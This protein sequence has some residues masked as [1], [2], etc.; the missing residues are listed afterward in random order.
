MKRFIF[1]IYMMSLL[2]SLNIQAQFEGG[3]GTEEDPYLISTAIQL[4]SIRYI[5]GGKYYKLINDINLDDLGVGVNGNWITITT[6][7]HFINGNN[8][9]IKNLKQYNFGGNYGKLGLFGTIIDGYI[10]NLKIKHFEI[11]DTL[12]SATPSYIAFVLSEGGN[13]LKNIQIDSSTIKLRTTV[14][15]TWRVGGLIGESSCDTIYRCSITNSY[16]EATSNNSSA[17]YATYL[18]A[19]AGRIAGTVNYIGQSFSY[20]TIITGR[21]ATNSS[22]FVGAV[23]GTIVSSQLNSVIEDCYFHGGVNVNTTLG[24]SVV[25]F[26]QGIQTSNITIRRC[27]SVCQN[28]NSAIGLK[29]GWTGQSQNIFNSYF[30]KDVLNTSKSS[31]VYTDIDSAIAVSTENMKV[32]STF[33]TW[34]F[35]S[36]WGMSP[37]INDGYPYLKWGNPYYISF[38]SPENGTIYNA[39]NS[40]DTLRLSWATS[41]LDFTKITIISKYFTFSTTVSLDTVYKFFLDNRS[42]DFKVV[43]EIPLVGVLTDTLYLHRLG[44]RYITIDTV[45]VST[46]SYNTVQGNKYNI[47]RIANKTGI[48]KGDNLIFHVSSTGIDTINFYIEQEDYSWYYL[49][50]KAVDTTYFPNVTTFT[51]N[52]KNHSPR[53][54]CHK[55]GVKERGGNGDG[56]EPSKEG[57]VPNPFMPPLD[58][59]EDEEFTTSRAFLSISGPFSAHPYKNMSCNAWVGTAWNLSYIF[60]ASCGWVASWRG[61]DCK[62]GHRAINFSSI[63]G[64]P[65]YTTTSS[66]ETIDHTYVLQEVTTDGAFSYSISGYMV[67]LHSLLTGKSKTFD[68]QNLDI[69]GGGF[70]AGGSGAIHPPFAVSK[71]NMGG[72]PYLL[73]GSYASGRLI[74]PYTEEHPPGYTLG[75]ITATG[76]PL[77]YMFKMHSIF[78]YTLL[79][80]RGSFNPGWDISGGGDIGTGGG[81]STQKTHYRGVHSQ[82]G[83][84]KYGNIQGVK[85]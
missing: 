20:N 17:S 60:D 54:T 77:F 63:K 82:D 39:E 24:G 42:F 10:I 37:F 62:V 1:F 27:Y 29:V 61:D 13:T 56:G 9:T 45:Y 52:L 16:V 22:S 48:I 68:M 11:I 40:Q 84:W 30:D 65:D 2:L 34:D 69:L 15:T 59:I 55:S 83:I 21:K 44:S 38:V 81:I 26:V 18:G 25:G 50:K 67:T 49:G 14:G 72:E 80:H 4:D 58:P 8:Y 43:A 51:Y 76:P 7:Q 78:S 85:P 47:N 57:P 53:C 35:I 3:A 19:L 5:E 79:Q 23:F 33:N 12:S 70:F 36:I 6:Y 64:N 46:I 71:G 28:L 74:N 41:N 75:D 73:I 31:T 32:E 66:W